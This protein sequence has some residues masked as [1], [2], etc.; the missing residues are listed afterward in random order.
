[1]QKNVTNNKNKARRLP[2]TSLLGYVLVL[3]LLLTGVTTAAYTSSA[4]ATA[5]AQVAKFGVVVNFPASDTLGTAY[6]N[7]GTSVITGTETLN[8]EFTVTDSSQVTTNHTIAVTLTSSLPA[9]V[10]MQLQKLENGE[11]TN[12]DL[13]AVVGSST[14]GTTTTD[15]YRLQFAIDHSTLASDYT[16]NFT[17]SVTAE[18]AD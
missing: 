4:T 2:L 3:T 6:Y 13:G 12:K 9:G 10:S 14:A 18:Q 5:T 16:P 11:Y 15:T 8:Y 7:N 17:V 1:M